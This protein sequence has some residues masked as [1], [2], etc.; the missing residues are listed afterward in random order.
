VV[1]FDGGRVHDWLRR[2]LTVAANGGTL[3][4]SITMTGVIAE[5]TCAGARVP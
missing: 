1:A 4:S 3:H 2:R 5:T